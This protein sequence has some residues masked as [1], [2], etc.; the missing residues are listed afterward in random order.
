[1]TL[2]HTH[3]A[4][5]RSSDSS[6]DRTVP[7]S[8]PGTDTIAPGSTQSTNGNGTVGWARS[9][10]RRS[11]ER[12]G[13]ASRLAQFCA[14]GFSGMIIDLTCYAVFRA[15]L[16]ATWLGDRPSNLL[17]LGLP[18]S[19]VVARASAILVALVWNFT[20]NRR[21]TFNDAPKT[22][23]PRQFAAYALGNALAIVVSFGCSVALPARVP[24]FEDRLQL[25]AVVGIVASTSISF[26]ASR[27][28]VFRK[29]T[30][31]SPHSS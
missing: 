3:N 10:K 2:P 27:W 22:G 1:M 24:F 9:I 4:A 8:H 19:V 28:L 30:A 20:L 5:A 13:N 26:S 21:V 14:V 25:A 7:F 29:T 11:D 23:L 31:P 15:A 18:T 12:F 17:G 16:E 6:A